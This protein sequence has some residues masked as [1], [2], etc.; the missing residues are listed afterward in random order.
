MK[1]TAAQKKRLGELLKIK[2]ADRSDAQ[3]AEF[4]ELQ[5][6]AMAVGFDWTV[7]DKHP[8]DD[9]VAQAVTDANLK[10]LLGEAL[11][12]ELASKGLSIEAIEAKMKENAGGKALTI[13]DIAATVKSV[14]GENQFDENKV[15]A[16]VAKALKANKP[17][18][19]AQFTPESLKA[20]MTEIVK[21]I[22]APSRMEH[23]VG[24][25]ERHDI[26][27]P[28]AHR[29][30]NL[31][32][33]M[34]QLLNVCLNVG[35]AGN[36]KQR[37][38][39]MNEGITEQQLKRASSAGDR[40]IKSLR[41]SYRRKT[42]T[43]G[44]S[45]T[46][47]EFMPID[48]ASELQMRLYMESKLAEAFMGQEIDMPSDPYRLPLTTTRSTWYIGSEGGTPTESTPGTANPTLTAVKLIGRADFSYEADEDSI[49]PVLPMLTQQLASGGADS[50]EQAII[51][52]DTT[53]THQDSDINGVSLHPG[54]S[55][56]GLRFLALANS[57]TKTSLASGG[58]SALNIA[59]IRKLL[60]K[61]G[62]K[63]KDLMIVCGT[64]AYNDLVTLAETLTA[65]KTGNAATARILTGESPALFG[66]PIIPSAQARE[67][68]NA[69]GVYDG[70]VMTK[71]SILVVHKPSFITGVRRQ[72]MVEVWQDKV[73]QVNKVVAS[74]RRSFIPL[75]TTSASVPNVA[76]GYNYTA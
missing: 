17:E 29:A 18:P 4:G 75:E 43:A 27:F 64:N 31:T 24:S 69:S 44:G 30:G 11:S 19:A 5:G 49:V 58:I 53:A 23:E 68:L 13:V 16:A 42:L 7:E 28:I 1:F 10:A 32:V 57:A 46:G 70:S 25:Q 50:Y 22:P 55:F 52:G 15:E 39:M 2:E 12:K 67:D 6:K 41:D 20:M 37:D 9:F 45:G 65:E 54:K 59:A 34:K 71:G 21:S 73:A 36:E 3:K 61:Y 40:A 26:E 72:F 74:Y 62:L 66:I 48:L 51:N 38:A 56:K 60:K 47:L 63:P 35:F 14:L 8:G 33:A 76:I